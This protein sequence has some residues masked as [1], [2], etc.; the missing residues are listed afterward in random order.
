MI[1]TAIDTTAP[2]ESLETLL[3]VRFPAKVDRIKLIRAGVDASARMCGLAPAIAGDVVLAVDEACQNI[4]VHGYKG[5]D[6]GEIELTL[7][8][9]GE[10][11]VVELRDQAPTVDPRKIQHR[12]LH[13]IK[14]GKLGTYLM[15]AIMDRVE[16]LPAP[17][18]GNLL[19]MY[20]RKDGPI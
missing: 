11:I 5:R 1:D 2:S 20:K 10:G 8:R 15:S 3:N 16:Y 14:P 4:I 12:A 19:R 7:I 18:G 17:G 9:Y 13:D 6:G